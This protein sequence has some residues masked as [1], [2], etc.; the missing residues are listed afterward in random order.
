MKLDNKFV[1]GHIGRFN[2]QKNHEFL[3]DIFCEI[4]KKNNKAVLLLVGTG[5]LEEK[6]KEKVQKKLPKNIVFS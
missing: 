5:P 1:V 3:I 2:N 4:Y 6:I